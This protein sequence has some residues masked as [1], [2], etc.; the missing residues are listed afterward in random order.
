[1]Q[2]FEQLDFGR[3]YHIYNKGINGEEIF[4]NSNHYERFLWLYQ[5]HI[6]DIAD[7]FAWCLM[8]NHFHFLVR[9]KDQE[10]IRHAKFDIGK[11]NKMVNHEFLSKQFSN[12]FNAYSQSFNKCTNRT[13]GLFQTPFRNGGLFHNP[14]ILCS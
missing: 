14:D 12:M 8:K 5:K 9:I 4:L 10:L 1:M 11:S 13:G 2:K 3:F 6:D 7:T